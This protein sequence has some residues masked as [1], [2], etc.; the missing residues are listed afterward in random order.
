MTHE[1]FNI[2]INDTNLFGQFWRPEHT[3]A[4]IILVHGMGEHASRYTDFLIPEFVANDFAV[5]SY[6][7]FG[8]GRSE[9]KSGHCPNYE[10][11]MTSVEKA[12]A[13]ANSLFP[14]KPKYLYGHSMGG[15][16]VIN[17]ALR[18]QHDLKGVIASSP[19]LR[20]AF[21]PPKWKMALGKLM[22]NIWPSITLASEL[23]VEA[24]SR[25][26]KEVKRYQEDPLVHDK[27]SPMFTFPIME[28]G[29]WAIEHAD[30]LDVP[31]LLLHGTG[32]RIIDYKGSV[33]FNKQAVKAELKLFR[34]GFHELH[35]DLCKKE[36]MQSVID[37]LKVNT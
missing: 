28:A 4:V 12:I 26:A 17:Y 13:K 34:D 20:L 6:D 30:T 19:F 33:A 1:T 36:F 9:G 11:L 21:Q 23:E 3:T 16:L 10:A 5:V 2:N 29:E 7:N 37:W 31:M 32:D 18:K 27:V 25:D 35:H 24:I 15:N 8:H 22:F 14:T